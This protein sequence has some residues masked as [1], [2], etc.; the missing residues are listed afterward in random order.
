MFNNQAS[1]Y[2]EVKFDKALTFKHTE[3]VENK[4]KTKNN[5]L[6]K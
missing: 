4:I 5:I 3:E 6:G 1:S 2:Q